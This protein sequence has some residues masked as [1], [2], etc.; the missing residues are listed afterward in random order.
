M[1]LKKAEAFHLDVI[2]GLNV[3]QGEKRLK[4]LSF[5]FENT[6]SLDPNTLLYT[7]YSH[8][9][10]S[11]K[12]SGELYW[13]LTVLEP[14]L[15]NGECNMTR[16]H[17][18]ENRNAAEYYVGASGEG[19]LLLMDENGKTWGEK[20][21]KGSIHYIKG[22]LA[23][24]LINTGNEQLKVAAC[25]PRDAGHDYKSVEEKEFSVRIFNENGSL[26]FKERK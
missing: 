8:E 16:G 14:V 18:H 19:I 12:K 7:V 20:V 11:E 3:K 9:S 23:H 1:E 25:W 4:D 15:I 13:G 2:E 6:S 26:V 5:I 17:F 21:E 10:F 24:R 22:T